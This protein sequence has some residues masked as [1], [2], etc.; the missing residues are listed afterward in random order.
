MRRGGVRGCRGKT[1][2][3]SAVL[4]QLRDVGQREGA[5][6]GHAVDGQRGALDPCTLTALLIW[7]DFV[8]LL[9]GAS[10]G[11]LQVDARS[12]GADPR[13]QTPQDQR[14]SQWGVT[15]SGGPGTDQQSHSQTVAVCCSQGP[16]PPQV[17]GLVRG[18]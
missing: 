16:L 2:C 1:V 12:V 18:E 5:A 13:G 9:T 3:S 14:R 4:G 17:R 6:G 7:G 11:A 10:K 15:G 8:A